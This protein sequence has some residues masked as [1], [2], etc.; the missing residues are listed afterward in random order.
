ML[1]LWIC[2]VVWCNCL[3]HTKVTYQNQ[4]EEL[5]FFNSTKASVYKDNI[6]YVTL[7]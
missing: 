6:K 4:K 7:K 2:V 5:T 3:L 1:A